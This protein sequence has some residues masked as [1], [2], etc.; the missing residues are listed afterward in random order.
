MSASPSQRY[1]SADT[2]ATTTG[3]VNADDAQ[4]F[5]QIISDRR[6]EREDIQKKAFT[7]WINNQLAT[8]SSTLAITD[9]FQDLRDGVVLLRLLEVLTG[10]EYVYN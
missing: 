10:N 5:Q 9:L 2:A 4:Q 1:S 3:D 6:Y 7:K 8:T